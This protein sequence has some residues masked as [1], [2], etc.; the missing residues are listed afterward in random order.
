MR[1]HSFTT[2]PYADGGVSEVFQSRKPFWSFMAEHSISQVAAKSNTTE[3]IRCK[4]L[5]VKQ[6]TEKKHNMP[7]YCSC[8]V[9]QV[10]T[11]PDILIRL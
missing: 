6:T 5:E 2:H 4:S 10:S 11:S 8:G 3:D 1:I 7:Q 9:I